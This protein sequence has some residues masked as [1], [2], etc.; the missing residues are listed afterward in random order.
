[1]EPDTILLVEDNP[2]D[3]LLIKRAFRKANVAN[4]LQVVGDGEAALCYLSGKDPY[5]DRH[6]YPWPVLI[7]LDLKLPRKSGAEVLAWLKQQPTLKR[8]P[9]VVLTSSNEYAD[10]NNVYDLGVNAYMVKPVTFD[11]LVNI[12]QM[13]NMHWIIFNEKPHLETA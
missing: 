12:V 8:V 7:L 10:I 2:K 5:S 4:P 6:H 3:V 13:L 9:V 1:M 11:T